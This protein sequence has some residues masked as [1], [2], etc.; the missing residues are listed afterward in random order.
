M[1][2]YRYSVNDD[3]TFESARCLNLNGGENNAEYLAEEAAEDYYSNNEGYLDKWPV[4]I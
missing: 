1:K 2:P 3:S 4:S